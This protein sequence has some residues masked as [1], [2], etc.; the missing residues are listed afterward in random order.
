MARSMQRHSPMKVAT[1]RNWIRAGVAPVVATI[2]AGAAGCS[3]DDDYPYDPYGYYD[4][5]YPAS[6]AYA[7]PYYMYGYPGVYY[8]RLPTPK[9]ANTS[10]L[11]ALALRDLAL[12]EGIC[13]GQ[14]TVTTERTT[15]PCDTGQGETVP[16]S[17]SVQL[18]GCELPGGGRLDGSVKIAASQ[19]LS[20]MNCDAGTSIDV[21]YTSTTTDLV[22]TAPS[23]A[24]IELPQ[25]TRTGTFTRA[26]D[27]PPSLLTINSQGRLERYD[28]KGAAQSKTTFSG[29]QTLTMLGANGGFRVDGT[30]TLQ[31]ELD[32]RSAN[33]TS[34]GLTRAE[35][36]CYPTSG[37]IEVAR[38]DGDDERWSFGPSCGDVSV[39]GHKVSPPQCF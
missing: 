29:M 4:Y 36:C 21:S 38:S 7:D 2:I 17:N 8:A 26:L 5:Y 28:A 11:P 9:A 25:V 19:T 37:S 34:I 14:V 27:A 18:A 1:R 16:V 12:G 24:R 3:S 13:P 32:A 33:V 31:D 6:Y 10:T 22:Y 30:L 35:G 15:A 20:D 39:N 23:G